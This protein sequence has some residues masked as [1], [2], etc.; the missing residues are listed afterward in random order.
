MKKRRTGGA[1][2]RCKVGLTAVIMNSD[3][4]RVRKPAFQ[5]CHPDT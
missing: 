5:N 3:P 4:G 2:V 1:S